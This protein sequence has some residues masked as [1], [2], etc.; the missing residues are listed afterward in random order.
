M[1]GCVGQTA[2]SQPLLGVH[3]SG[4]FGSRPSPTRPP[5]HRGS[6]SRPLLPRLAAFN[7]DMVTQ[8]RLSRLVSE[9]CFLIDVLHIRPAWSTKAAA[10]MQQAIS[11]H[12]DP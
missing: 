2:V 4:Y 10:C 1:I 3:S 12:S 5:S 6:E 7:T 8:A 9:R 11:M